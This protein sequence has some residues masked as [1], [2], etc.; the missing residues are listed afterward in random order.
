MVSAKVKRI[1]TS[2]GAPFSIDEMDAMSDREGWSWIYAN[3]RPAG[4]KKEEVC[5]TGFRPNE[6][7]ELMAIAQESGFHVAK[8]VTQN[9]RYLCAGANAGPAKLRKAEDQGVVVVDAAGFRA[10]CAGGDEQTS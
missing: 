9:L 1:L 2:M 10:I 7:A 3:P 5:F 8:S 6:K 4:A